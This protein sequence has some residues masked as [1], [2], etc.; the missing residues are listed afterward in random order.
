MGPLAASQSVLACSEYE[1]HT[2]IYTLESTMSLFTCCEK[3][4]TEVSWTHCT[5][6]LVSWSW[7]ATHSSW[8]AL[9]GFE[10]LLLLH[11]LLPLLSM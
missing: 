3:T 11:V 10:L 4:E 9:F 1:R 5:N 6:P 8:L 2:Y 7:G